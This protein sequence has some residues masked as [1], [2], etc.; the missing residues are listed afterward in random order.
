MSRFDRDRF[1]RSSN[2]RQD[3]DYH[4]NCMYFVTIKVHE[5]ADLFGA[6]ERGG[7]RMKPAAR[8]LRLEWFALRERFADVVPAAF[9]VMP[10]HVHG[11]ITIGQSAESQGQPTSLPRVAQ[12]YKSL[13]T[14]RYTQ[15]VREDAWEPFNG[16]VWQRNYYDR[17]IRSQTELEAYERYIADNPRRRWER[18]FLPPS[19]SN[20]QF[21]AERNHTL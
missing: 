3:H 14:R 19:T 20:R 15:G 6:V 8:M 16:K 9:I 21:N 1:H 10:D 18:E 5:G 11:I 4:L 7:I 17:I 2:R 12:A 13:T